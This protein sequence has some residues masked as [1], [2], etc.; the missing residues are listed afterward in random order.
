MFLLSMMENG[1]IEE[2]RGIN[3][4]RREVQYLDCETLCILFLE[5]ALLIVRWTQR[6]FVLFLVHCSIVDWDKE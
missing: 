4:D 5:D 1:M 2:E 6:G 3:V